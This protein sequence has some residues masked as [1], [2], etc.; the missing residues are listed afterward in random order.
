VEHPHQASGED[1]T[2]SSAT[3][4]LQPDALRREIDAHYR[5]DEA[6]CVTA[7]LGQ[8]DVKAEAQA[9]IQATAR[10]LV[11]GVRARSKGGIDAFLHQYGLSTQEGVMLMCIAEALL[12][13][14]DDATQEALIR[15]KMSAANWDAHL[16]RSDSVFVNAS[17]WALMLTGRVVGLRGVKGQ[18]AGAVLRRLVARVGEPMIREA[19]NQAMRI[20][21]KQFVMGRTIDEALERAKAF[22]RKGYSYS[23]DML[24]EA[25]RT[26]AD[27]DRFFESYRSAIAAIGR[28]SGG[29][30]IYAGPGISVKLSALHPRYELW[31]EQRVMDELVPRM[32]ALAVEAAKLNI[33]LNIDAEEAARLDISLDVIEAVSGSEDLKGWDGFGV[34]V[35]AYQKRAPFVIDWL[36]DMARRHGRRLMV[37]LV[38]GAYWDAEIKLS[39]ELALP[40]YPV[41]TRKMN[42]DVAYLA[43]ARKL[44]ANR[45]VFYPQFATHNAHSI[46]SVLEYA[47]DKGGFEFQRLHGMGEELYEGV[48]EDK[49]IGMPCRI[50]APVGGHEDLL[51]YL[52]R[53]LLENGANSS[54]V[55]RIQDESQPVDAIIADPVAQVQA[56]SYIPHPQI[57]QPQDLYGQGRTNFAGRDLFDRA[58]LRE[59]AEAMAAAEQG[60]WRAGPI[61]EG[62]EP[63]RDAREVLNPADRSSVVGH[64]SEATDEDVEQALASAQRN[65]ADW[66][67]T[68]VAERAAALRRIADLMEQ[69]APQLMAITVREAGKTLADALA[70]VR[71]A[72]D[73]CRYYAQ[74]AEHDFGPPVRLRVPAAAGHEARL[75]GG[76]VF[77]CISPWNFPLA[78]FAGQITAALAAGNAVVAKPAEQTPLIAAAAVR[79]MHRA[80]IPAGVLHLLPG[81]GARV[82]GALVADSRVTGVCFTGS[83]EVAQLINRTLARRDGVLCPLIAETGG[84]N[85]MIVDSSALPEQVARDVVMSA[86]QSAGQRCSALR[87]LFVQEDVADKMLKMICGA[88]EELNVGDPSLLSSDIG[89]VIDDEAKGLLDKHI[90]RM[91]GEA[92]LLKQI[93]PGPS[94]GRG[95]F[96]GPVAFELDSLARLKREVFGPVLHV[97]RFPGE[98]IGKVVDSINATGYGLTH[99]IH[100][101]VDETRDL[102]LERMRAGNA[103]VNRNQIGAVVGVQP[104]GGEGLSGTG[105]KAG[106][107][108]YLLRF[109]SEVVDGEAQPESAAAG[110]EAPTLAGVS[111]EQLAR[112]LEEARAAAPV[113]AARPVAERSALLEK[114]AAALE[115]S[116]QTLGGLDP[117]GEQGIGRAAEAL[118]FYAAQAEAEL[119][120]PTV[121]PGPTGERNEL[122][123]PPRGL[124]ACLAAAGSGFAA[125]AA[126]TGAALAAGNSVVLWHEDGR[127]AS[128][129]QRLLHAAGVPKDALGALASGADATLKDVIE[130]ERVDAVALAGP[131]ALAKAL[132]R[133][134]AECDG[135]IRPLIPFALKAHAGGAPGCPL[136]GS[137]AYLHRFVLERALSI[138]TTA[139]GGNASLFT[140]E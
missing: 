11:E 42:T 94:S 55:N 118:R 74:R 34:V 52:V 39:Q 138:D 68:P 126:E 105:P 114:A 18:T 25:A 128:E 123:C 130:D 93:K 49:R 113:W 96:V 24:G 56:L 19:V 88:M 133:A 17:T 97:I 13:I 10:R 112:A 121:L 89:P 60:S 3:P 65:A 50:Y 14:P 53:R 48:V 27:A 104:F 23:Y 124:V 6:Q 127:V 59:L 108:H 73:F 37:R 46:A 78:I 69:E 21:G 30:G 80:G 115:T 95:S 1:E 109:A 2:M 61:I 35:Q 31:Q 64:A 83:T 26:M 81:D 125:L 33:G 90:K 44:L 72:V 106:G 84:L 63:Q 111:R 86:F 100:T 58:T 43:C 117:D 103:Y 91:R 77:C 62:K 16:G 15:D 7:L 110:G 120:E 99:G 20:M 29:K 132:N 54:F 36:A 57:P 32:H 140:M 107:P 131:H 67:T 119:A 28:V 137:P 22:E 136:A 71:E 66:A 85:A 87:V 40:D 79:L 8:L 38:K 76:G 82:G 12:R 122:R 135:A 139:S 45:D 5:A 70:E 101:R 129:L 41:Y 134:L 102:I 116:A 4:P 92:K 9:R 75:H 47:G 98:Q 51:A